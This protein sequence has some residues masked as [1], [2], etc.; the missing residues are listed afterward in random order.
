M[1]LRKKLFDTIPDFKV[2]DLTKRAEISVYMVHNSRDPEDY[3]F[4][5]DFEEF[6]D[7]SNGGYF[8]R[9]VVRIFSGRD[10]FGR[11]RFAREFRE[12]FAREFDRMRAELAAQKG[13]RGWLS[14]SFGFNSVVDV[15]G[16]LVGNLVLAAAT[17]VGKR[18]LGDLA[19]FRILAGKSDE[20]KLADEIDR[21]KAKVE[22]ALA[23]IEITIHPELYY[24]AY[25][26][27]HLG[28]ISAMDRDAWP[29]PDYVRSHLKDR[30]SGSWW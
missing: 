8:V 30:T 3:F 9:P 29:L 17:S 22:R 28:K 12:V 14:W 19:L 11:T 10:D 7:R 16:G 25:R 13:K 27:G 24:H 26:D 15:F 6:V 23:E 4:L 1:N 2:P 20:A 18:V 5:F 21:T